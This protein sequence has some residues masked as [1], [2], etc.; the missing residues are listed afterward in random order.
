MD[1]G[2]PALPSSSHASAQGVALHP[3]LPSAKTCSR[4]SVHGSL[5]QNAPS[6][7]PQS[8]LPLHLQPQGTSDLL[9]YHQQILPSAEFQ[10][11]NREIHFLLSLLSCGMFGMHLCYCITNLSLSTAEQYSRGRTLLNTKTWVRKMR[12][13]KIN[14][15]SQVLRV[16][17]CFYSLSNDLNDPGWPREK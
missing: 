14:R 4:D 6:Y 8:I 15:I 10:R 11:W 13:V 3:S 9:C 1:Y 5:T 17:Q 12:W 7:P 16:Y 2:R